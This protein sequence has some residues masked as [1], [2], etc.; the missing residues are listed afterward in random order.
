VDV[1]S[2]TAVGAS[3]GDK[4]GCDAGTGMTSGRGGTGCFDESDDEGG[5]GGGGMGE[6]DVNENGGTATDN[7]HV[8]DRGAVSL[9][10][11][12]RAPSQAES[13]L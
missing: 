4:S 13:G 3:V 9:F 10:S 8:A 5:G 11:A 7:P 1:V 12:P 6:N 2:D